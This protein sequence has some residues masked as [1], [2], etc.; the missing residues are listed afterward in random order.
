MVYNFSYTNVVVESERLSRTEILR[1]FTIYV[2][3]A[4]L[5]I[6]LYT[7]SVPKYIAI[8]CKN[9]ITAIYKHHLKV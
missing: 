6:K 7:Y 4:I 5:L 9:I 1:S 3:T 2:I 8:L